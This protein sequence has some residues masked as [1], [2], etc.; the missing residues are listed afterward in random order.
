MQL[1]LI[2]NEWLYSA[3][4][5]LEAVPSINLLFLF[6][7][8][9]T[10]YLASYRSLTATYYPEYAASAH[11][12]A[13]YIGNGY[14]DVASPRSLTSIPYDAA[15]QFNRYF[16]SDKVDCKY[17][18][19]SESPKT[20]FQQ[21]PNPQHPNSGKQ[22]NTNLNPNNNMGAAG[23]TVNNVVKTEPVAVNFAAV[24]VLGAADGGDGTSGGEG[25]A[26]ATADVVVDLQQFVT[27]TIAPPTVVPTTTA[28]QLILVR[29]RCSLVVH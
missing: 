3:S 23:P 18:P 24:S 19:N 9:S 6:R 2:L 11:A 26:D 15:S 16:E 13:G 1:F 8:F 27:T 4:I 5:I 10:E 21:Q 29:S 14:F 12:A 7:Y 22:D 28:T 20:E 17:N 25:V